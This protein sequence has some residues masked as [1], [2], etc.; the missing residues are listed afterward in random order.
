M[1]CVAEGWITDNRETLYARTTRATLLL[2]LVVCGCKSKPSLDCEAYSTK[3]AQTI[4]AD[5]E[6]FESMRRFAKMECEGGHVT[7]TLCDCVMMAHTTTTTFR[8]FA[9]ATTGEDVGDAD[10]ATVCPFRSVLCCRMP[11]P[12]RN[13][14]D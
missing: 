13:S 2:L 3:F 11:N 7:Q 10:R 12:I 9:T 8:R 6:Q 4:D 1:N 5:P 14:R